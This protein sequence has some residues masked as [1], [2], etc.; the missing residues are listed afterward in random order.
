MNIIDPDPSCPFCNLTSE[1]EIILK[2]ALAFAIYDQFPVNKG[3]ALIIP[4][5]HCVGYFDLSVAEQSACWELVNALKDM[6]NNAFQPD[7]YNIGVNVGEAAGQT[8]SHVHI[9]L[10]PR[11][12]GDMEEPEG[13]VRGVIPEKRKYK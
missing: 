1:K 4:K 10:I 8:V 12:A 5:R 13:G 11:Y 3:H 6:L 7:G 9:H 2:S